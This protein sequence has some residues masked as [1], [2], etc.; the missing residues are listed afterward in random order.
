MRHLCLFVIFAIAFVVSISSM[1]MTGEANQSSAQSA[2][3]L[4]TKYCASCHGKDGRAKTFKGKL[5]HARDLTN[6]AWQ[7]DASDERLF[8]SI[9]NGKRKMPRFS[10]KLSEQEIETLVR[11]V[12]SLKR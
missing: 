4:Y 1:G 9:M 5:N 3:E 7:D 2:A 11:Y 10:Q 12:R 8:N 6:R